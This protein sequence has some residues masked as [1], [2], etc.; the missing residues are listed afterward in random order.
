MVSNISNY[1]NQLLKIKVNRKLKIIVI[2]CG[3]IAIEHIKAFKSLGVE[4]KSIIRQNPSKNMFDIPTYTWE[5]YPGFTKDID[6]IICAVPHNEAIT[7]LKHK[8]PKNIPTLYEKPLFLSVKQ[9]HLF[10][11]NSSLEHQANTFIAFNRRH[12]KAVVEL[13]KIIK[14]CRSYYLEGSFS[15]RYSYLINS[16]KID[17]SDAPV[18]ITSH[19]IDMLGFLIGYEQLTSLTIASK[20]S[21]HIN[22]SFQKQDNFIT[23][24]LTPDQTNNHYLRLKERDGNE[25]LLSPIEKLQQLKLRVESKEDSKFSATKTYIVEKTI[26]SEEDHSSNIKPGFLYQAKW[27][28]NKINSDLNH[29]DIN[30]L[31]ELE[32]V[33]YLTDIISN[34]HGSNCFKAFNSF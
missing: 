29:N 16:K 8:I 26:L 5:E 15:D 18:Y 25:Y 12:Y 6:G 10:L 22:F 19:W 11:K 31:K 3:N 4:I 27:F 14:N 32:K 7:L 24:N 34:W 1:G 13:Q 28:L 23:I 21:Y 2:G 20:S 9:L 17:S 33:Y 30:H